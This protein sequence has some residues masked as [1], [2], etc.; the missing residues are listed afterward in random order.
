MRKL[1]CNII[2]LYYRLINTPRL[3]INHVKVGKGLCLRGMM[4]I[5]RGGSCTGEI[6]IGNNVHIN[7]SIAANP[8][9]GFCKTI[10]NVRNKGRIVIGD[11]VGI[12][13]TAIVSDSEIYIG[14][15]TNIGAGTCI[16]DTDFHSLNPEI[17]LNGDTNIKT[18]PIH[19]G[20]SV[21]IGGH[22]IILKGVVI[23]DGAVIGAGSVVTKSVPAGEIWAGNPAKFVGKVPSLDNE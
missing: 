1:Y 19:I 7:S 5:K 15:S 12:S 4:F 22:V 9:G 21:F 20:K 17:R 10:F 2:Y 11:G 3:L 16:Y 14:E 23:G 13:N 8:I 6:L 18:R